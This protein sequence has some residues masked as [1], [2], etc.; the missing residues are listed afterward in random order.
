MT[1]LAQSLAIMIILQDQM[2]LPIGLVL[3]AIGDR[4]PKTHLIDPIESIRKLKSFKS[5]CKFLPFVE[6][7][8]RQRY[9]NYQTKIAQ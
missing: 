8:L 9:R 3:K 6:K 1:P 2:L 7:I 4:P 5:R